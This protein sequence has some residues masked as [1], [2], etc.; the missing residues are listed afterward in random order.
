MT[1]RCPSCSTALLFLG[2][3]DG[4]PLHTH[5][6]CSVCGHEWTDA[7]PLA[8]PA[9]GLAYRLLFCDTCRACW[10]TERSDADGG[11][12]QDGE[13]C[14]YAF[15]GG[16]VCRGTVHPGQPR[17]RALDDDSPDYEDVANVSHAAY[18]GSWCKTLELPLGTTSLALVRQAYRRLA[19][20]RH[21][22]VVGGSHSLMQAL[23]DAYR[24]ALSELG[25][26]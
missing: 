2:M 25:Q 23:N 11:S 6:R 15:G 26:R 24:R 9:R 14:A 17:V 13:P 18:S 20:L 22:D 1:L 4:S 8:R 12:R 19:K 16:R 5:H 3:P 21:P 10:P 7:S